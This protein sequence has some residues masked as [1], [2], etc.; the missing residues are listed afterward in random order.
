MLRVPYAE[1]DVK[2]LYGVCHYAECRYA[3]VIILSDINFNGIF[4]ILQL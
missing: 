2:V 4:C 1:F 3:N